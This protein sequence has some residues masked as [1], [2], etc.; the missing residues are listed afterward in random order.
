MVL[1]LLT[2]WGASFEYGP[3]KEVW[4]LVLWCLM[5][6]I[7]QERNVWHFED[8]ETLMVELSKHLLKTL[9][10]WMSSHHNLNVFT[11]ANFLNL[12][13]IRSY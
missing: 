11:Y 4:R 2:S 12:F 13:S 8:V 7:W 6:C 5:W 1:E 3:A 10:I 9:Y